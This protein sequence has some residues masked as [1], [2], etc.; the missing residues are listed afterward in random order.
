MP[1]LKK[2]ATRTALLPHAL[3]RRQRQAVHLQSICSACHD[4]PHFQHEIFYHFAGKAAWCNFASGRRSQPPP[5][6]CLPL[7][8]RQ[9]LHATFARTATASP[10]LC[11]A[12]LHSGAVQ[13]PAPSNL[14]TVAPPA[15]APRATLPSA[16]R[17]MR[18][19]EMYYPLP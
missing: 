15:R 1:V 9:P 14:P 6:D 8:P 17:T 13:P 18:T 19:A 7:H 4:A 16:S 11:T 2:S 10:Q 3:R 12:W 5:L